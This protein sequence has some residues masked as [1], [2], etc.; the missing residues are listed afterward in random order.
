MPA[1]R[2]PIGAAAP[3]WELV[4]VAPPIAAEEPELP[5]AD[6]TEL[7]ATDLEVAMVVIEPEEL[8]VGPPLDCEPPMLAA[9]P[10]ADPP[11]AAA[12]PFAAV[13]VDI[14]PSTLWIPPAS[15]ASCPNP[16]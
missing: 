15:P 7:N 3:A 14:A 16:E 10:A 5:A 9:D 2:A 13:P 11:I 1:V 12:V 8:P 4:L 6:E